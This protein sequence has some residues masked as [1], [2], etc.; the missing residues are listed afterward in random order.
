M[1]YDNTTRK[2]TWYFQRSGSRGNPANYGV[3]TLGYI[4]VEFDDEPGVIYFEPESRGQFA[5]R[6][7]FMSVRDQ[8]ALITR[9]EFVDGQPYGEVMHFD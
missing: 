2:E 1:Q 7:N 5:D 3:R 8:Q 4:Q 9:L 6:Q